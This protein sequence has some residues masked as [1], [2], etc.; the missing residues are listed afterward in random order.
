VWSLIE[1]FKVF[2]MIF[3]PREQNQ[4][5]DSL[6]ISTLVFYSHYSLTYRIFEVEVI[7]R[8]SIP[9]NVEN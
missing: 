2:D 5:V 8:P 9:D 3:V 4:L 1:D 7:F 6:A